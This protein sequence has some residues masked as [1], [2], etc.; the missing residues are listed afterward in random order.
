MSLFILVAYTSELKMA[1]SLTARAKIYIFTV[2]E[3]ITLKV[4]A[5]QQ[6]SSQGVLPTSPKILPPPP[7]ASRILITSLEHLYGAV[8]W[9]C[10]ISGLLLIKEACFLAKFKCK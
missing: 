7:S 2:G 3:L 5:R 10:S 1:K 8:K 6:I 4:K 9:W